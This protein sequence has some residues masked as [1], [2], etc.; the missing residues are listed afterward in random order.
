MKTLIT[1]LLLSSSLLAH[2]NHCSRGVQTEA[3]FLEIAMAEIKK[4]CPST[5]IHN[6]LEVRKVKFS[7]W[8]TEEY[9]TFIIENR[10]GHDTPDDYFVVTVEGECRGPADEFVSKFEILDECN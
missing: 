8:D 4:Q 2:A 1:L 5:F 10:N 6:D 9:Y 7:S 3:R